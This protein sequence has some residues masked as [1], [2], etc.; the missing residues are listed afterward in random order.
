MSFYSYNQAA[1]K[2]SNLFNM[3]GRFGYNE[4]TPQAQFNH[5]E[6]KSLPRSS[7]ESELESEEIVSMPKETE[8]ETKARFRRS[9]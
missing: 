1:I 9:R 2:L 7:I 5:E 4:P 8:S 3:R 6:P